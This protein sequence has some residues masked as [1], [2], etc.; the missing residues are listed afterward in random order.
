MSDSCDSWFNNCCFAAFG[1]VEILIIAYYCGRSYINRHVWWQPENLG[2][3]VDVPA[4][5]QHVT[6]P[7]YHDIPIKNS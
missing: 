3:E 5:F 1:L 4:E 6:F 2:L 7:C